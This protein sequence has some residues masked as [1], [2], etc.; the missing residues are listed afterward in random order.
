[1]ATRVFADD[2][3]ERLREF[4]EIGRDELFRH[5]TLTSADRAFVDP[6]RGRGAA[7]RLGLGLAMT[8]CTLP[9]L[10][11]IPDSMATAPPIAVAR[12]AEQLDLAPA[13][14]KLYG[15]RP[16]TRTDHL[17]PVAAYLGGGRRARWSSRSW[18]SSC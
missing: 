9:W 11:F 12:L 15:R 1:L 3:L 16:K 7:D 10:G 5:F 17:R 18:T 13:A 2:E 4:P 6:G 8:L 14:L